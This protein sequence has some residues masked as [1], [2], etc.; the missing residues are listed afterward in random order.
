MISQEKNICD[1][2]PSVCETDNFVP[3]KIYECENCEYTTTEISNLIEHHFKNPKFSST[4]LCQICSQNISPVAYFENEQEM[5]DELVKNDQNNSEITRNNSEII[6]Q[7]EKKS[8]SPQDLSPEV[9][10]SENEEEIN[11]EL[12]E[13]AIAYLEKEDKMVD[14]LVKNDQ[15]NSEITRNNS[16]LIVSQEKNKSADSH[17]ESPQAVVFFENEEEMD[18]ELV[19]NDQKLENTKNSV[20]IFQ[21]EKKCDDNGSESENIKN[22]EPPK[23]YKCES[24]EYTT[25]EISDL[26]EH[27]SKNPKDVVTADFDLDD[28]DI[29]EEHG[30]LKSE[31]RAILGRLKINIFLEVLF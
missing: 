5:V 16:D 7:E 6:C 21:E 30:G 10:F 3:S 26:I 29:E 31:K 4:R 14:D 9:V 19:K 18:N 28:D 8:E 15:N 12:V 23:I 2:N 22:Y 25:T 11:N 20:I 13:N 17:L 24:C 27:H 1:D